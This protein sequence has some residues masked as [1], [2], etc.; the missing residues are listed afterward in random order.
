M[1][2]V[3]LGNPK[4]ASR[5]KP[6]VSINPKLRR[7]SMNKLCVELIQAEYGKDFKHIQILIDTDASDRFWIRPC[8]PDD[9]DS[10]LV[11]MTTGA[12][13]TVSCSQ[14]LANVTWTGTKTEAFLAEWDEENQ[15]VKV[16]LLKMK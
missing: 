2:L 13:R 16:D 6:M 7:I 14:L 10:R 3:V 9:G 1:A 11:N 5:E 12:T 15:A 8:E 4:Y